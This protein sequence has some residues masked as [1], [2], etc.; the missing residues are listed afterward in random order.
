[1]ELL[2]QSMQ[3]CGISKGQRQCGPKR[4]C[5]IQ[6]WELQG[7]NLDMCDPAT[8]FASYATPKQCCSATCSLL[9]WYKCFF[10]QRS[11][12][13][14]YAQDVIHAQDSIQPKFMPSPSDRPMHAKIG[15]ITIIAVQLSGNNVGILSIGN[16]VERSSALW[17]RPWPQ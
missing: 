11:Q 16:L 12:E 9:Q 1:M 5:P 13:D 2:E 14:V 7:L 10:S 6:G 4:W 17:P 3:D 15:V 8:I